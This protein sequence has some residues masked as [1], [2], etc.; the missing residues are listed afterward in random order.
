[1]K[2]IKHLMAST[3]LLTLTSA[4]FADT[5]VNTGTDTNGVQLDATKNALV[6]SGTITNATSSTPV[7]SN[8]PVVSVEN[9]ASGTITGDNTAAV[10]LNGSV[11]SITNA[12]KISGKQGVVF[13][14]TLTTLNNSGTIAATGGSAVYIDGGGQQVDTLTNSGTIS[15]NTTVVSI[16]S[17]VKTFLNTGTINVTDPTSNSSGVYFF[18]NA[19]AS[20]S[21]TNTGAISGRQ[22]V[23]ISGSLVEFENS[24]TINAA[25]QSGVHIG[26]NG[27]QMRSFINSGMINSVG[28]PA[29]IMD[30]GVV[31]FVNSGTIKG[32]PNDDAVRL[33]GASGAITNSGNI[34]GKG[35]IGVH[36]SALTFENSGT[37][38]ADNYSAIYIRGD[39]QQ[40]QSFKNSGAL[41]NKEG[42]FTV[43]IETGVKAFENSGTISNSNTKAV[44]IE[45]SVESFA[46]SGEISSSGANNGAIFINGDGKQ[47]ISFVNSGTVSTDGIG[48]AGSSVITVLSGVKNFVNT[49]EI[50]VINTTTNSNSAG[51]FLIGA[52]GEFVNEGTISGDV[53]VTTS[54]TLDSFAN[55]GSILGTTWNTIQ[56]NTNND[57]RSMQSF[58]NSGTITSHIKRAVQVGG[59]VTSFNNSGTI[60]GLENAV[61]FA[62]G[63][64]LATNTGTIH[65]T[66]GSNQIGIRIDGAG[67]IVNNSGTVIGADGINFVSLD[68]GASG[69]V[70]N[71]GTIESTNFNDAISFG[72]GNDSA[73]LVDRS[74]IIGHIAFGGGLDILNFAEYSG[75]TALE[76][77]GLSGE[78]LIAGDNLYQWSGTNKIA[79]VDNEVVNGA[80][81]A[82]T[83]AG[84]S[85]QISNIIFNQLNNTST[86]IAGAD[87]VL[88]YA[89][90]TPETPAESA[91]QTS[92]EDD[93]PT[94]KI[95]TTIFGGISR[96]KTLSDLRNQ[97]GGVV[98]GSHAQF[99]D[100]TFGVL[101]GAVKSDLS[102]GFGAQQIDT[103]TGIVGVYGEHQLGTIGLSFSALAGFSHHDSA[104][105][106]I[107]LGALQ[108]AA[109]DYSSWFISPTIGIE[110][111]LLQSDEGEVNFASSLNYI[112]GQVNG[113]TETGSGLNLAVGNASIK[114]AEVRF[115]V[116]GKTKVGQT[117]HGAVVLSGKIGVL[118]QSNFGGS[119]VDVSFFGGPTQNAVTPGTS[120]YGAYIGA[121]LSAPFAENIDLELGTDFL[122]RNDGLSDLSGSAKFSMKF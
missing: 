30:S 27:V 81:I 117:D 57:T 68:A 88:G 79:I 19:G 97:Y 98:V 43:S 93:D 75:T 113:Y 18:N 25:D 65:S 28:S 62:G 55:S 118:A 67:G 53:G 110:I 26:G 1:M 46:N 49:G 41:S 21:F 66:A 77:L 9:S 48:N 35:G 105:E 52:S 6:N 5:I 63:V 114:V 91:M 37:I 84:L 120:T 2:F 16:G 15:S 119:T 95:W 58:D 107:F 42:S 89:E 12:G 78:T 61:T 56:L 4:A 92:L 40:L 8:D 99:G 17:G 3:F 60:T 82:N 72:A 100:T 47:V 101:G 36:G 64:T 104:R 32:G 109:A 50:H 34:S 86:N 23:N 96:D 112:G 59:H 87:S 74:R 22:G 54:S 7:F 71:S 121:G 102:L 108:T 122:L 76:V 106:V 51:V 10:Q 20:G 44:V 13:G 39:G 111:P 33:Y 90:Q 69:H 31:S 38:N 11:G 80:A 115:E 116:N 85:N 45:K 70:I 24:G 29:V 73:T 83:S 14:N 94:N 103:V